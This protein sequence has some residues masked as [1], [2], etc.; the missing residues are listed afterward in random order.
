MIVD[1]VFK[2]GNATTTSHAV[3][4]GSFDSDHTVDVTSTRQGGPPLPGHVPGAA[5]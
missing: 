4:T 5:T 2:L 3:V 1:P